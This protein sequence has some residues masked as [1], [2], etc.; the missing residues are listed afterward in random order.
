MARKSLKGVKTA[1]KSKK[2]RKGGVSAGNLSKIRRTPRKR[3]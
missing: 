1:A 3:G 2:A